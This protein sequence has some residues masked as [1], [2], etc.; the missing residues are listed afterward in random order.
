MEELIKKDESR[1]I[2]KIIHDMSEPFK[3]VFILRNFCDLS[4]K[5]I[6]FIFTKTESWARVIHYRARKLIL[7]KFKEEKNE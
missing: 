4:F 1:N 5:D 6:G 7:K 2:I 3:E